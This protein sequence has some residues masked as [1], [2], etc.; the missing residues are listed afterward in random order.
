MDSSY[1]N[2]D[3]LVA[4]SQLSVVLAAKVEKLGHYLYR[5]ENYT[6]GNYLQ[7][8]CL[9]QVVRLAYSRLTITSSCNESLGDL[10][11]SPDCL[12]SPSCAQTI[13]SSSINGK[14]R[15][16]PTQTPTSVTFVHLPMTFVHF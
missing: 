11:Y 7:L 16:R 5:V 15:H 2:E 12:T 10:E 3:L 4:P 8:S 6:R 14:K 9:R 13:F 1:K